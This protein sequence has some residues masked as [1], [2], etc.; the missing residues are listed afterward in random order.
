LP[1]F[2][3][4]RGRKASGNLGRKQKGDTVG[5]VDNHLQPGE[6]LIHSATVHWIVYLPAILLAVLALAAL[7]AIPVY[8]PQ[9]V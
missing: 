8:A 9:S 7:L 4:G 2:R 5:Y 3:R 6:K 1:P